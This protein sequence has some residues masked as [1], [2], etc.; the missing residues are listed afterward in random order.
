MNFPYFSRTQVGVILLLG[1]S[2][3]LLYAWRA[4]FWFPPSPAATPPQ[5]LAFVEVAGAVSRPGVHAFP[6]PPTLLEALEKAGGTAVAVPANPTL[7]SGSRLEIDQAGR[8]RLGRMAGRQR[9]TLGLAISLNEATKEDLEALPGVGPV[10][11]GRIIAHRNRHGPFR[12]IEDLVQI[13][14]IGPKNLEQIRSH[15]ILEIP[16]K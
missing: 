16:P 15:L 7:A 9:L 2:L 1:A 13:P 12:R 11:A 6:S 3:L 10:L 14:G 5:N 8:Y 4:N